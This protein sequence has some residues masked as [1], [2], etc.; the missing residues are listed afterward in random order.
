MLV[1]L[2]DANVDF[3]EG[4]HLGGV[5]GIADAAPEA[6]GRTHLSPFLLDRVLALLLV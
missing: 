1:H 4:L 3:F 6:F 2:L 5:F